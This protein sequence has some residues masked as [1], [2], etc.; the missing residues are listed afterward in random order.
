MKKEFIIAVM[1]LVM[2]VGLF[3]FMVA[4]A[5]KDI[6]LYK[7]MV[8]SSV[9]I[10]NKDGWGS[11]VF[12]FDNV[13]VTAA[14]VL[15]HPNLFVE[16]SDGSIFE[17]DDFYIDDKEDV[18]FIFVDVNELH[19]SK[20]SARSGNIGDIVYLVG[21][22]NDKKMK[23]S[24]TKGI[25]SHLNRDAFDW[26]DLLQAD[27]ASGPGSS[28]G[29]LYNFKGDIIGICVANPAPYRSGSVTLCESAKS[30]LEAYERC[31]SERDAE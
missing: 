6:N 16:F 10:C 4:D 31:M 22:P 11:G 20:L 8:D 27:V 28:G 5:Q 3:G 9:I 1:C 25:L 12:I 15:D 30:I 18:G 24:L 14:H 29:P 7:N 17:F 19:V 23:F 26:E 13:I 21:A 2:A